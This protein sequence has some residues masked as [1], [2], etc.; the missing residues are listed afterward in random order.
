[1][2]P[3]IIE[4]NNC[5]KKPVSSI[6]L[7]FN[8]KIGASAIYE[9]PSRLVTISGASRL[10]RLGASANPASR[11]A[12]RRATAAV[13]IMPAAQACTA[14]PETNLSGPAWAADTH[15]KDGPQPLAVR[16]HRQSC[17]QCLA[18]AVSDKSRLFE[19]FFV[20]TATVEAGWDRVLTGPP[21]RSRDA[22]AGPGDFDI[23]MA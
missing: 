6:I 3:N 17:S 11:P 12:R 14:G 7:I 16:C 1:M 15:L 4:V 23:G 18:R 13:T 21:S 5:L 8:S 22:G 19:W 2:C 9:G 20:V 10:G